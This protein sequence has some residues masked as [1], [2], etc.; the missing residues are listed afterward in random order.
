[1]I[2]KYIR[3]N[4]VWDYHIQ[5]KLKIIK[6]NIDNFNYLLIIKIKNIK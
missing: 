2:F 4:V 3:L 1:V 5:I 6:F